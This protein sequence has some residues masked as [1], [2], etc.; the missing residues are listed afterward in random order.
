MRA[1]VLPWCAD[2]SATSVKTL[3]VKTTNQTIK[4][5]RENVSRSD[6]EEVTRL[7]S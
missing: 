1:I 6:S 7:F 4:S 3:A 2:A 5:R